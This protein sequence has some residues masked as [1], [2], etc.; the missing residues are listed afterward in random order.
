MDIFA[1]YAAG[2]LPAGEAA[3]LESHIAVCEACG[4]RAAAQKDVWAALDLWEPVA[5]SEDFDTRLYERI[6]A[7]GGRKWWHF[8]LRPEISFSFR[9]AGPVALACFALV[10]AFFYRNTPPAAGPFHPPTVSI[11]QNVDADQ[12]ERTLDDL[13]MLKQLSLPAAGESGSQS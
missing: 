10:A 7:E 4:A 1:A 9:T 11:P 3:A 8:L 5:I 2:T 13:E 12:V 6:A